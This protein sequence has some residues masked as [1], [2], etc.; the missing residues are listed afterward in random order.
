MSERKIRLQQL[1]PI[2]QI[3]QFNP[4]QQ[5]LHKVNQ[6]KNQ[7]K[8]KTVFPSNPGPNKHH[9]DSKVEITAFCQLGILE[10]QSLSIKTQKNQKKTKQNTATPKNTN[11]TICQLLRTKKKRE[12]QNDPFVLTEMVPKKC[13]TKTNVSTWIKFMS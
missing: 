1:K 2:E 8:K 6:H 4:K 9:T 3:T 7:K 12:K 11:T 10:I 5:Q 13:S